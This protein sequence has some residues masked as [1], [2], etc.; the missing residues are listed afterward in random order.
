[1]AKVATA[2]YQA[3]TGTRKFEINAIKNRT[4]LIRERGGI[5]F[6]KESTKQKKGKSSHAGE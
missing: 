6:V 5:V 4:I 1:M 3:G 2:A